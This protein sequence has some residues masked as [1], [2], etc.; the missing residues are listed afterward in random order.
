MEHVRLSKSGE[1]SIVYTLQADLAQQGWIIH[2]SFLCL[3]VSAV[4]IDST[5][6]IKML[7]VFVDIQMDNAHFLDTIKFN[8]PPG[9]SLALVSTIQFVAALQV[10]KLSV[11]LILPPCGWVC[12]RQS[13]QTRCTAF[14]YLYQICLSIGSHTH[15][16]TLISITILSIF[17][18]HTFLA[19]GFHEQSI[20]KLSS[21]VGLSSSYFRFKRCDELGRPLGSASCSSL[22]FT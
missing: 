20:L 22:L 16:H 2:L 18:L 14:C 19:P 4:P 21:S 3:C 11:G 15:I 9:Q 5:A 17:L 10:I 1:P 7:Y 13:Q 8:F 12:F 6:G